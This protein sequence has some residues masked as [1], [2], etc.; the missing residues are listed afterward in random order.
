MICGRH[1]GGFALATWLLCL[2]VVQLASAT[3]KE[4][5]LRF[6]WAFGA[7]PQNAEHR[8]PVALGQV[9]TLHSG[10]RVKMMVYLHTKAY[11]YIIHQGRILREGTATEL[12]SDPRVR[13]VY[14][15]KS[16]EHA[17]GVTAEEERELG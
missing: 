2:S 13:E 10:D 11:A 6:I 3:D 15:G 9:T 1:I 4:G 7:L 12:V 5:A 16:F 8:L 14:L 17:G